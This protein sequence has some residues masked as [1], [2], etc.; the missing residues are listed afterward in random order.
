MRGSASSARAIERNATRAVS[1][2]AESAA[3]PPQG[4]APLPRQPPSAIAAALRDRCQQKVRGATVATFG[5]P[6][7]DGLGTTGGFKL[8]IEDRGNAGLAELQRICDDITDR[9]VTAGPVG[10]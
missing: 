3:A 7:V 5:G 9:D 4:T 10:D 1:T 6:P 2:T 8:I